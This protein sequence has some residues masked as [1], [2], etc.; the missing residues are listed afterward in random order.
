MFQERAL[1]DLDD[2]IKCGNSLIGPAF[3]EDEQMMLLDEE[4]HYRINV[5]DWEAAFPQVFSGDNPGFHAV[6][7]NPPYIRIQALKEFASVEVEHYKEAYRSASKGNYDIYVVFVERGLSLLNKNGRLGYILPHKFFNARYGAPVRELISEGKYLSEVVHFG[8]EQVFTGATTYTCLMFLDKSGDDEFTFARVDNLTAWHTNGEAEEGRVSAAGATADEWNFFVGPGAPL[9]TRLAATLPSLER[10]ASIYVGV[11]TSADNVFLLADASEDDNTVV[12]YSKVLSRTV[13]LEKS[14]LLPIVSGTD[15]QRYTPLPPRQWI[16]FPYDVIGT[17][18]ALMSW[19]AIV[20]Q[21]PSVAA[22]LKENERTLR[23]RERRR[24][25]NEQWYRF[26]RNQNISIQ[27]RRKLCVPRLVD[28]LKTTLDAQ[29]SY[30]LDNVD[31]N[32]IRL[33]EDQSPTKLPYLMGIINSRLCRW[34]FPQLS[35]PFRGGFWSANRQFLGQL[36]IRFIDFSNPEDVA[37][38]DRLVG[39]VER[40]LVPHERLTEARIERERTVIGARISAADHLMDL[41]V[42]E[43][44]GLSRKR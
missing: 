41:R 35:A 11:Q 9:A 16:I 34:L 36:P 12:A 28:H 43:L 40:M 20:E 37:R 22:Y 33:R 31:V 24:F 44:C 5:F 23:D 25:D 13:T 1:P 42:Y 29:G 4:E 7:G 14:L 6:I 32:G 10:V 39:L 38:H 26:G 15:I 19:P 8:D 18:A 21:A 3:Y 30:C 27:T 2:N 17:T